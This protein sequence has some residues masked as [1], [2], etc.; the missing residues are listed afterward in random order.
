M[1]MITVAMLGAGT[2][3]APMA[4]RM[5]AHGLQVRVWNRT[6]Q[7]AQALADDGARVCREPQQASAGAELL[8]TMLADAA[9]V[10]DTAAAALGALAPGAIWVQTSTVGIEG[11]ERCAELA[12]RHG[13]SFID[14]P[15]LGTREPAER[16]ELVVL[17]SGPEE[18]RPRC[19]PVFAAIGKRTLW[20]GEAGAG[21][22]CKLAVNSWVVGVVGVL[23]E[24]IALAESLGVDPERF[25]DAVGGGP[26]DLP[27][28]RLKGQMMIDR[29]FEDSQFR[30][31]LARKDAELVLAAADASGLEVPIMSAVAARLHRAERAG[32]GGLDMAATFLATARG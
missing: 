8:V 4:R 7:R 2:M 29:A 10:V 19:E 1:A 3:G 23:A 24:T 27:Y 21:T 28:A 11:T 31:A 22:R 5:L 26:L 20:L 13:V 9:A 18:A 12:S 14:A 32:H 6:A 17:A 15:V 30:L 16:G 25:F